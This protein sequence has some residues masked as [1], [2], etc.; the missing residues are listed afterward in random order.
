MIFKHVSPLV[1]EQ[2]ISWLPHEL[3]AQEVVFLPDACPGKAPLPTGTVVRTK[4]PDWRR[5]AISDCGCGMRLLKST[6]TGDTLTQE[7]WDAIASLLQ[8]QK[9]QLGDL[10]G[11]N[12]FLDALVSYT[13]DVLYFLIH[14]GSR[15][16]SNLVD[17]Y[18]DQP[19]EFDRVYAEVSNW[20]QMNREAVQRLIESQLGSL[21]CI[22]DSSHNSYETTEDGSVIIRKGAVHVEPGDLAVI[23]SHMDGDVA[24][25]RATRQ[26]D[27]ILSSLS[28]GTGRSMSRSDCKSIAEDYDFDGM[29]K[30]IM[31]P[32]CLQ[33]ESLRTE[34]PYAYRSLDD[35]LTLLDSY[36]EIV[37]RY[38]VVA[39]MG[40]L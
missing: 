21:V 17:A 40:H 24:L 33:D 23:P 10:G 22:L 15:N 37:E 31:L 29:R 30:R 19:R 1:K 18:I 34:G 11:G 27:E 3:Q 39:Y 12:H 32:S 4:Q 9:N 25:V 16:E 2:L 5:L 35:C 6:L 36:V 13:D 7:K 8:Q 38:A 14:T 20:A 26:V 28:H